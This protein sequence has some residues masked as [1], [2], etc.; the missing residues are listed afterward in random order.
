[1][2][3]RIGAMLA[4]LLCVVLRKQ[5]RIAFT[6]LRIAFPE[7]GEPERRALLRRSCRNLGRVAAE[8][9]HLRRLTAESVVDYVRFQ[10]P[11]A[12]R[13][14]I[15]DCR[16]GAIVLTAHF[17]NWE[18]LAYA[19]GLLG[20]PV[21]IVHRPLRNPLVDRFINNVRTRAG[22]RHVRK[23][24][25]ARDALRA[26]R[27]GELVVI[28]SDQNQTRRFGV[29][30]NLFGVPA[31]TTPGAAR[32]AMHAGVP[33]VPA[34]LVRDG[35]TDRHQLVVLPAIELSRTGD[36][37]ADI[38]ASTQ[39]CSDAI[40]RMLRQYPEQWIWFHKRWRTRPEGEPR[41]Y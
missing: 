41:I 19:H 12:W 14:A 16:G 13:K 32:L 4:S 25:A 30:V 39:R 24:A 20:Y 34:F 22:T 23:K 8:F 26:L 5:R 29:F 37:E 27:G 40:E 9:C 31:S 1:M 3:L 33:V 6:N 2:A 11:A 28:P 7:K 35:E 38:V 18:L 15:A 10:D 17:G 21:T 36:R